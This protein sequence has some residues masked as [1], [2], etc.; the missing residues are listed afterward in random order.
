MCLL[1]VAATLC[2]ILL[3]STLVCFTLLTTPKTVLNVMTSFN[4]KLEGKYRGD[5]SHC[6]ATF[7]Y[8]HA[9][10]NV[11]FNINYSANFYFYCLANREIQ[12]AFRSSVSWCAHGLATT[13]KSKCV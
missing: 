2:S 1:N 13:F 11:L 6:S 12:A 10:S 8:V 4:I 5:F 9:V 7:R 3:V